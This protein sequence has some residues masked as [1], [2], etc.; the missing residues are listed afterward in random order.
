MIC[1]RQFSPGFRTNRRRVVAREIVSIDVR[2]HLALLVRNFA[3]EAICENK[4]KCLTNFE[5]WAS[6]VRQANHLYLLPKSYVQPRSRKNKSRTG[7]G[8]PNSQSKMYP[9]APSP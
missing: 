1:G 4:K 8:T 5:P 6:A 9:A 3:R 7:M 2:V